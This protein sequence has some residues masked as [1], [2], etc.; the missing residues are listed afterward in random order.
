MQIAQWLSNYLPT[1]DLNVQSI[2]D[3]YN[4]DMAYMWD[5]L[6]DFI[7]F[8]IFHVGKILIFGYNLLVQK[9]GVPD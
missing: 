3:Q 5:N 6:K 7:V 2:Q 1:L 8:I 9:D 4:E